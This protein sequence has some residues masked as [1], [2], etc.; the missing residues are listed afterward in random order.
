MCREYD[1]EDWIR[2]TIMLAQHAESEGEVP[3]GAVLLLDGKII[4]EGWNSPIKYHDPTAHAEIIAIRKGGSMLANYRLLDTVLYVTMEP[5]MMCTGAIIHARISRVVFGARDLKTSTAVSLLNLLEYGGINN[6]I[7]VTA[8]ILATACAKQ[9]S[10][11][12]RCRRASIK[13]NI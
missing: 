1:D 10:N 3:V 7:V 8:G 9:L 2:Y 12:F 4:G 5:C 6:H 11:F 13:R